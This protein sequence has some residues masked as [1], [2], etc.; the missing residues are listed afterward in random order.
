MIT[1][2]EKN[3]LSEAI[4][5]VYGKTVLSGNLTKAQALELEKALD[6]L[7]LVLQE[8]KGE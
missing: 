6:D 4:S 7:R 3:K 1:N 5:D 2:K 8:I